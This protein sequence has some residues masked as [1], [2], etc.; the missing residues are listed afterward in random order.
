MEINKT[1]KEFIVTSLCGAEPA[2]SHS[3]LYIWNA[4]M[5]ITNLL[6]VK[7]EVLLLSLLPIFKNQNIS[8]GI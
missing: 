2:A 4:L 5:L 7:N 6:D 8:G 3:N 1:F